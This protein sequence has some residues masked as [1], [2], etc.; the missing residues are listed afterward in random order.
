MTGGTDRGDARRRRP[1]GDWGGGLLTEL[2]ERPMDPGYEDAARQRLMRG[3]EP[4]WRRRL[5]KVATAVV[6][7]VFG[8]LIAIAYRHVAAAAPDTEKARE[9][10]VGDVREQREQTDKLQEDAQRLREEVARERDRALANSGDQREMQRLRDLEAETGL[11]KVRGPG[12]VVTVADARPAVDP[13][14]GEP[15]DENLG[16]VFDRDLQ[17]IVNALWQ[18]GAEAIAIDG[19]RLSTTSTIRAAG[20][21]ILVDFRP[22]S[23]PYTVEAIGPR[24]LDSRFSRTRTAGNFRGFVKE[25]GMAFSVREVDELT[26]PAAP[27]PQLRYARP[28]GADRDSSPS[29]GG[30]KPVP[31]PSGGD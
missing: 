11:T 23:S 24:D 31:S 15:V 18:V 12:A 1:L 16:Q 9:S 26:L 8:F 21:A 27:D 19:Q 3:P 2:F 22:V 28:G 25:Y 17:E 30:S 20:G 29:S 14:T 10:L 5:G 6:A 7:L 13:V 4:L